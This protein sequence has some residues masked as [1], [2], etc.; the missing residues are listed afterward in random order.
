MA[1]GHYTNLSSI[2]S[3]SEEEV[4]D[5]YEKIEQILDNETKGRDYTVVAKAA[6][7]IGI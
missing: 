2:S 7:R 6:V 1:T 5:M 4:D 3:S